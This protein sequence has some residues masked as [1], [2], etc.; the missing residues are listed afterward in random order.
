MYGP[1]LA[2]PD[3]TTLYAVGFEKPLPPDY[4]DDRLLILCYHDIPDVA[5]RDPFAVELNRMVQHIEF[6]LSEGHNFVSMGQVVDWIEKDVPLPHRPVLFTF[7]DG[8]RSYGLNVVPVLEV[9][10]IPSVLAV[11][12]YWTE[13]PEEAEIIYG[14]NMPALHTWEEL[15]ELAEHPLVEIAGHTHHMHH[16]Q[17]ANPFGSTG[18]F[19][20]NFTYLPEEGRYWTE[21]EYDEIILKDLKE[22][23]RMLAEKTGHAPRVMVWPFG[24]YNLRAVELARKAGFPYGY[25][26]DK[27]YYEKDKGKEGNMPRVMIHAN[28][29]L[30]DFT[31]SYRRAFS[32]KEQK[33]IIHADLDYIYN[34]D[35]EIFMSNVDAFIERIFAIHPTTVYLQAF[36]DPAG[37]GRVSEVYFANDYLPVRADIFGFVS[38]AIQIRGIKVYAWMPLLSY[39]FP[40]PGFTER[41]RVRSRTEGQIELSD[42]WFQRLSP[43]SPEAGRKIAALY[44]QLAQRADVNG[45]VFQEDGYLLG[46]EDFHPMAIRSAKDWIGVDITKP[47]LSLEEERKWQ[48]LKTRQLNK[49]A[50]FLAKQ[51]KY[52]RPDAEDAR[53]LYASVLTQPESESW[54]AQ[55][56]TASLDAHDW[57]VILAYPELNKVSRP[58]SWLES[59]VGKAAE[60]D[61]GLHRTIFQTQ[62]VRWNTAGTSRGI[63]T[64]ELLDRFTRM[65]LAGARH[66]GYYPDDYKRNQPAAEM[67]K[68]IM[69]SR[70]FPFLP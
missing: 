37:T 32:Y 31:N 68:T 61:E 11:V 30:K 64:G 17:Q 29:S 45:I 47:E 13:Y 53:L 63:P 4:W 56:F 41:N 27:G 36:A 42:S 69:S 48:Q 65:I 35:P 55:S 46:N 14:E 39:D 9:Y 10:G 16:A 70:I 7:D 24:A 25:S 62:A 52:Y 57:V 59:L 54:Y 23:H 5:E 34:E 50:E 22:N 26:L 67:I 60:L 12:S 33:R 58:V 38:R 49:F 8:F 1:G 15:R 2:I 66:V 19:V 44:R 3:A 40:E 51:I 20:T 43:F 6:L 21:E 18:P 28:M